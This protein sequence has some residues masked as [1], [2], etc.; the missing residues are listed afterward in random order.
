M[1]LHVTVS[2]LSHKEDKEDDSP[3]TVDLDRCLSYFQISHGAVSTICH[4]FKTYWHIV[5]SF[6]IIWHPNILTVY[7]NTKTHQQDIDNTSSKTSTKA[8][9]T[10]SNIENTWWDNSKNIKRSRQWDPHEVEGGSDQR[11]GEQFSARVWLADVE[12]FFLSHQFFGMHFFWIS[13]IGFDI[14]IYTTM[15]I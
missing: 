15:T 6:D 10:T 3:S 14:Q 8:S 5:M 4:H 11:Q 1:F 12:P 9:T 7:C 13:L 2:T